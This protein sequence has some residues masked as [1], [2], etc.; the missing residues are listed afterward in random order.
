[1][2]CHEC[3]SKLPSSTLKFCPFCGTKQTPVLRETSTYGTPTNLDESR[4]CP[5]ERTA[6]PDT[7][8]QVPE[9]KIVFAPNSRTPDLEA[10]PIG[11]S[12]E[13]LARTIS[14]EPVF[15]DS[16][17]F[18]PAQERSSRDTARAV[19]H[20]PP[21]ASA[22]KSELDPTALKKTPTD[23][24]TI[25]TP[26]LSPLI[27]HPSDSTLHRTPEGKCHDDD[28]QIPVP[29]SLGKP[30]TITATELAETQ[31]PEPLR[32]QKNAKKNNP[33]FSETAW[34]MAVADGE[35]LTAHEGEA[36]DFATIEQMT[37]RYKSNDSLSDEVR[38]TYSLTADEPQKSGS[39]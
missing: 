20:K 15:T 33:D 10:G 34:F 14:A 5:G 11:P 35:Q 12:P 18:E 24:T 4:P 28:P 25:D 23:A 39:E 7:K 37:E 17:T 3:G 8:K 6:V 22:V 2:Y 29:L 32:P 36:L 1:M 9:L 13:E 21:L 26:A 30:Q 31:T 38:R 19:P 16:D 27:L